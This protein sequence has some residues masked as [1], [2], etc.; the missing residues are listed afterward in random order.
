MRRVWFAVLSMLSLILCLVSPIL[1][2]LGK[3]SMQK[4]RWIFLLASI[5]WFFFATLQAKQAR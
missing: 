4:Y 1:Y 2:F 3:I 5:A